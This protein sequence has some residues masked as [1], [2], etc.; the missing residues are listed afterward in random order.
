MDTSHGKIVCD[1]FI[2]TTNKNLATASFPNF[3]KSKAY[4]VI[5]TSLKKDYLQIIYFPVITVL[6]W[7]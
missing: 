3:K 6:K 1:I 2:F 7:K 4:H 5:G